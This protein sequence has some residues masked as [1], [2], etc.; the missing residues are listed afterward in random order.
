MKQKL[1]RALVLLACLVLLAAGGVMVWLA[2]NQPAEETPT[3]D[4]DWAM[5]VDEAVQRDEADVPIEIPADVDL[6]PHVN[7]EPVEVPAADPSP[8][9]LYIPALHVSA[10]VIP[11]AVSDANVMALPSDLSKVGWLESTSRLGADAGS[12]LLAAHVT[13]GGRHGA[14]YFLGRSEPGMRVTTVD[15]SGQGTDWVVTS[16]RTFHKT[17]LPA[18]IFSTTGERTLTIVTCG[19]PIHR[20]ED[21]RLSYED[22]IVVVASPLPPTLEN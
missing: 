16:V 13:S 11:Q 19:G 5:T 9:H 1:S 21:G 18:E 6:G 3:P 8:N 20:G 7:V 15:A 2:F 12:S 22:N 4:K 14:L 10:P 17:A